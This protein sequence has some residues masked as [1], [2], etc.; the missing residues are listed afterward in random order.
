MGWPGTRPSASPTTRRSRPCVT[1]GY[2]E[3]FARELS[4]NRSLLASLR[5]AIQSGLP[6][7]AE[8]GGFLCLGR[9]LADE[10]GVPW[11]MA[12]VLPGEARDTGRLT[13]FGYA[14][15]HP[16][17]DSLLFRRGESIPCHCFHHWDST[18]NGADLSLEKPVT[19]RSWREGFVSPTLYAGFPHLS[20][21]GQPQLARRFV[22]AARKARPL[23]G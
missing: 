14:W 22:E 8:C 4:A 1:G 19:S 11:P 3:R 15:I 10:A 21:A 9:T 5:A 18:D 16:R 23:P 7:V 2:P 6:T 17:G 20:F 12:D 13:R